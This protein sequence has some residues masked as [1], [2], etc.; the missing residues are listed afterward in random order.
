MFHSIRRRVHD[1]TRSM[2]MFHSIALLISLAVL[3]VVLVKLVNCIGSRVHLHSG[4]VTVHGIGKTRARDV[5][6]LLSESIL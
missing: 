1:C 5:L 3:F 4:R 2:Q 6:L